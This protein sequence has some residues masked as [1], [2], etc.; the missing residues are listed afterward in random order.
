V[1]AAVAAAAAI[2]Q[3]YRQLSPE[4][5]EATDI[6]G[7]LQ[8]AAGPLQAA[9]GTLR[10]YVAR[11]ASISRNLIDG[12]IEA[13]EI[14]GE[15][16]GKGAVDA[17]DRRRVH[18]C[19]L[20]VSRAQA[21]LLNLIERE[22]L[23][24]TER[25]IALALLYEGQRALSEASALGHRLRVKVFCSAAEDGGIPHYVTVTVI[26]EGE[27]AL[28]DTRLLAIGP[29]GVAAMP[30]AAWAFGEVAPGQAVSATFDLK[31][32]GN[33]PTDRPHIE[34]HITYFSYH[35]KAILSRRCPLN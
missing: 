5:G 1:A 30:R 18:R 28:G 17:G 4:P 8:R 27:K 11:D 26:N 7:W 33:R 21:L 3:D 6:A 22:E 24:P 31:R 20:H 29:E 25:R 10:P 19:L 12:I 9:E 32:Q 15:L 34:A 13:R 35:S 14:L 16:L 23:P 2:G